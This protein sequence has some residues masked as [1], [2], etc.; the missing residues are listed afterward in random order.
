MFDKLVLI[1]KGAAFNV[2]FNWEDFLVPSGKF[3]AEATLGYFIVYTATKWW[4]DVKRVSE[5]IAPRIETTIE[6]IIEPITEDEPVVEEEVKAEE[7]VKEVEKPKTKK[8]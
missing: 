1:N 2:T 8:K 3:E 5:P 7:P 6:P 4:M